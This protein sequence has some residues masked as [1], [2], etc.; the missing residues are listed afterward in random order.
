[1]HRLNE[2]GLKMAEILR[3]GNPNFILGT[4]YNGGV[5]I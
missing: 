5:E 3:G 2:D 4:P 1:M